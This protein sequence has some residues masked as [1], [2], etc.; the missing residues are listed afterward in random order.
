MKKWCIKNSWII[1]VILLCM[2]VSI[3]LL[4][5]CVYMKILGWY[6]PG[7][8]NSGVL[9]QLGDY[10]GGIL[11]TIVSIITLIFFISTFNEF[12][13]Q[14]KLIRNQNKLILDQYE[15]STFVMLLHNYHEIINDLEAEEKDGTTSVKVT[16]RE[17]M[18]SIYNNQD[19]QEYSYLKH[20]VATAINIFNFPAIEGDEASDSSEE[21]EK[22]KKIKR[23]EQNQKSFIATLS[24]IEKTVI[25]ERIKELI[26]EGTE[27]NDKL[28][29]FLNFLEKG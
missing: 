19:N 20:I 2:V 18:K 27:G 26:S 12:K 21:K 6:N 9:G 3:S 23:K 8:G 17:A 28:N 15:Q 24:D 1:V 13:T 14:N 4:Q 22:E 29:V 5:H 16:G 11:G 25:K 7:N 10:I